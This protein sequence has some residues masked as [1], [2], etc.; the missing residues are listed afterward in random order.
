MV[1]FSGIRWYW[2]VNQALAN[3]VFGWFSGLLSDSADPKLGCFHLPFCPLLGIGYNMGVN[4]VL[5]LR[6][7]KEASQPIFYS[8][9]AARPVSSKVPKTPE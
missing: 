1:G 4:C 6:H 3:V 9:A 7:R 5:G 8:F 2:P